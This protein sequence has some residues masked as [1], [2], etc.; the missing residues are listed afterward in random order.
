MWLSQVQDWFTLFLQPSLTVKEDSGVLYYPLFTLVV[1]YSSFITPP[2]NLP[3][4][5]EGYS[6]LMDTERQNDVTKRKQALES[7]RLILNLN[8]PN[9][10]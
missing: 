9:L 6:G 3:Q 7:K 8:S 1:S 4:G 2:L 10:S 5:H